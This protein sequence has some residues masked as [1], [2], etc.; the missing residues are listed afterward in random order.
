MLPCQW[1]TKTAPK[2]D[3]LRDSCTKKVLWTMNLSLKLTSDSKY[4]A[5][6]IPEVGHCS[7]I[8]YD[9]LHLFGPASKDSFLDIDKH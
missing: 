3:S 5:F 9:V 8:I 6:L 2:G 7:L 4:T 1:S